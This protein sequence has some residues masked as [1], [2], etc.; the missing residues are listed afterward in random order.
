MNV[1]YLERFEVLKGL[2][3]HNLMESVI[4]KV[5]SDKEFIN[6][7]VK[8]ISSDFFAILKEDGKLKDIMVNTFFQRPVLKERIL[9]HLVNNG[10]S[11]N[12]NNIE[13]I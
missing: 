5:L 9:L 7:F 11:N 4:D 3:N 12:I 1:E 13:V 2:E 8:N 6:I 10:Y